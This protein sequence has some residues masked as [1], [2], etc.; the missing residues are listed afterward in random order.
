MT[1][2]KRNKVIALTTAVLLIVALAAM[3]T[4]AWLTA[5]DT[6]ENT[7]TVGTFNKPENTNPDNPD[8]DLPDDPD[9][10]DKP[11]TPVPGANLDGYL[12]EPS[13]SLSADA[14]HKILSGKEFAKDPYVGIGPKSEEAVVY[15]YVNNPFT[16]D[17]VY[18]DL[19]SSWTPVKGHAVRTSDGAHYVSGLFKY[20][21][22][23]PATTN[24]NAWT[25]GPVFDKVVVTSGEIKEELLPNLGDNNDAS[26]IVS[27]FLH[28]AKDAEG[29][30]IDVNDIE[31]AAIAALVPAS[32]D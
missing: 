27:A 4:I 16:N 9:D 19:N 28:Q 3:G 26:I 15:V 24:E 6:K 25:T 30:L 29:K 8:P 13:W 31:K 12:I 20:T 18:F 2:N 5:T 23:L 7:F 14:D 32:G 1:K 22:T 21:A 17:Y 10:P 11:V